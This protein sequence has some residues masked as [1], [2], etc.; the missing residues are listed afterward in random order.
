[1]FPD[2]DLAKINLQTPKME[3][4]THP[5]PPGSSMA[6]RVMGKSPTYWGALAR[7]FRGPRP[8]ER[9]GLHSE[10]SLLSLLRMLF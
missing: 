4:A 5:P 6:T 7:G 8:Q 2:Y 10:R 3:M 9:D 1:M